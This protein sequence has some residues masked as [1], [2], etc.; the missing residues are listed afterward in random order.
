MKR[1][2][3][4]QKGQSEAEQTK[5]N[6]EINQPIAPEG[7]HSSGEGNEASDHVTDASSSSGPQKKRKRYSTVWNHFSITNDGNDEKNEWANC[8]YCGK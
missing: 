3:Q 4:A 2:R 6:E 7:G 5:I 8:N 1:T